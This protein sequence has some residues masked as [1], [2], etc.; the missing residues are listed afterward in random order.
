MKLK[1]TLLHLTALVITASATLLQG[2]AYEWANFVGTP[3]G[4]GS[5]DGAGTAARFYQPRSIAADTA[6]TVY[7]ADTFNHT[8]RKVSKTGVVTTFAGKAG[9][10]GAADGTG[11]AAK[12][13]YPRGMVVG[14]GGVL[15]VAD[16]GNGAIRKITP[17]GVVTTFAGLLGE[18]GSAD[19]TVSQAR[20]SEPIGLAIQPDGTLFVS[21]A[22]NN[23]IRKISP[24]GVVT[25]VAGLA[26]SSGSEDGTGQA[27]RF[28]YPEGVAVDGSGT[29]YVADSGNCTIRKIT[30]GGEVTTLAG[31]AGVYDFAEGT[32]TEARFDYP[33]GIAMHSSGD[34]Y[35]ADSYNGV[36]R[37]VTPAGVV[38]SFVGMPLSYGG[39]DGTGSAARF[40]SCAGVALDAAGNFYIVDDRN[41]NVR[42]V[43]PEGVVT[44]V[45]GQF[46]QNSSADG[47]G[48]AP[49]STGRREWP[50]P[51]AGRSS[52]RTRTTKR[53]A[54]PPRAAWWPPMREAELMAVPMV[55]RRPPVSAILWTLPRTRPAWSMWRTPTTE[56]SARS[57]RTGK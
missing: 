23:N 48:M 14:A 45:A 42:K 1:M 38:S 8:I 27:A 50:W 49:S 37:K 57:P 40:R 4:A 13:R 56:S 20:F 11:S 9:I 33:T 2:A 28:N 31:M 29:L 53:Y 51:L 44:T 36:L 10:H 17:G 54:K 21:D 18:S 22:E 30:P 16:S 7:V 25:T 6:G 3:G 41:H 19:G 35:V 5:A 39:Q 26:G 15:Y 55:R 12:F 24:A 32:G 34:I 43:T 47:T 46:P 52:S